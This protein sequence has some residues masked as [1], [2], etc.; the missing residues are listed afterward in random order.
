[1]ETSGNNDNSFQLFPKSRESTL[2]QNI[3]NQ[4]HEISKI[5]GNRFMT[6]EELQRIRDINYYR[7]LTTMHLKALLRQE[8]RDTLSFRIG[9]SFEKNHTKIFIKIV[10][11]GRMEIDMD[12]NNR[13]KGNCILKI[14][15]SGRDWYAKFCY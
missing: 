10:T 3:Y 15:K 2:L 14:K 7:Y 9:Y 4:Y 1:M 6:L 5:I 11:I 12:Y 13:P 8:F